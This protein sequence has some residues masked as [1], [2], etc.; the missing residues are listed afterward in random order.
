[1]KIGLILSNDWELF[2]DG[3]GNYFEIQHKP[4]EALLT[5]VENHGAKLT[6]MAE[7]GQQ[8]AHQKICD[9]ELWA[10]E[11]ADSWESILKETI[12][13]NSD[14]QLHLHPQWLNAKYG[15][16]KWELDLKQWAISSLAPPEI[17]K[18]L[19]EGKQYLDSLLQPVN[20]D[21]E[22]IAFRAGAYCIQPSNI[23]IQKLLNVGMRCDTSVTKGMYNHSF[24][25]YRDA[26]SNFLPWFVS[27]EDIKYKNQTNEGLLEIPI[28]SRAGF[29]FQVLT[30]ISPRL[31]YLI[32]F[33]VLI[34]E[35][36]KNWHVERRKVRDRRYPLSQRP[37]MSDRLTSIKWLLSKIIA[38][39]SIQLDYDFLSPKVFAKFL[40]KAYEQEISRDWRDQDIVIPIMASGHVKD[41][42]NCDNIGRILSE[43]SIRLK[44][45]VVFWTLSDAIEYWLKQTGSD[46]QV[47]EDANVQSIEA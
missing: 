5:T 31:F 44:D 12:K 19:R 14:V 27:Q 15:N 1:M 26:Y 33:G 9:R 39:S 6:V 21:Y 30:L 8:W 35:Q 42:H 22:C 38:R 13:R 34:S 24:F 10:G 41:M 29:D 45:K 32:R 23:V 43:I 18:V 7:V 17:E 40:Q 11:V 46:R 3:S 37:F 36:D 2:G 28:Y 16:N 4:L 20:P 25:D 47:S